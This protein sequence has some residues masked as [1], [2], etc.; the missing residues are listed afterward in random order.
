M[1]LKDVLDTPYGALMQ[2]AE[3]WAAL[4]KNKA[5]RDF[6]VNRVAQSGKEINEA[7]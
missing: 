5:M 6:Y 4:D 7:F 1:P 3:S 2:L